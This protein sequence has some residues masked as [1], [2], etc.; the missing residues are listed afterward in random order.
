MLESSRSIE[1]FDRDHFAIEHAMPIVSSKHQYAL[2]CFYEGRAPQRMSADDSP[3]LPL[4]RFRPTESRKIVFISLDS[5]T[6]KISLS[7]VNKEDAARIKD[8]ADIAFIDSCVTR[9]CNCR[10]GRR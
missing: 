5:E 9:P 8:E 4:V 1:R 7:S 3:I 6:V 2:I 10:G